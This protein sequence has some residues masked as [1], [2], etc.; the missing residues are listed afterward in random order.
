MDYSRHYNRLVE[1]ANGRRLEGYS[2]RHHI[3]P[4]CLGGSNEPG[5]I[6]VLTAEEHFVAHQLLVKMHPDSISLIW[7]LS[8]M[9][10]S[11]QRMRRPP[12]KRYGWLRRRFAEA[13]RKRYLGKPLTAEH[14]A[15]LSAAAKARK[16]KPHSA[17]AK[18]R[19]SAAS[20]GKQKSAEHRA[21]MSRAK[22]GSPGPPRSAEYE[23]KRVAGIRRAMK[24]CDRSH[25][26]NAAYRSKQSERMKAVW[27]ERR[28]A[29]LKD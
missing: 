7:A 18:A 9:T 20:K 11:T 13:M 2:E 15:K 26:Q 16:H 28:V 10:H 25:M 6:V 19:M 4:K 8:A 17:E 3:I 21:A 12:N 1:R 24:T 29:K 5:N 14:R 27:A 22:K 23:R